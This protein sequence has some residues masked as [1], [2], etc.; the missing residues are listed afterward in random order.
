MAGQINGN[1]TCT[2]SRSFPFTS[3]QIFAAFAS[4]DL[5]ATWWGPDNFSNT[6][7]TFEFKA[8]GQWKFIM[9]G[10]DG[11]DY[12]NDCIFLEVSQQKIIIRHVSLPNFTLTITFIET[13]GQTNLDWEQ[14]FDDPHIAE[15]LAHIVIPA[16]EQNLNRLHAV[17]LDAA[18]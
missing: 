17:L 18:G 6:I 13:D 3:S 11:K 16:N 1:G 8:Q 5:L 14:A 7:E 2:T 10:P 15:S 9:H 4:A 12:L